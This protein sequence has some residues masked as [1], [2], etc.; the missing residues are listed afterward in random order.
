MKKLLLT[1]L[2]SLT[3]G[4][5]FSTNRVVNSLVGGASG[6]GA[7]SIALGLA[8]IGASLIPGRAMLGATA[9]A[10][11]AAAGAVLTTGR[12]VASGLS[13]TARAALGNKS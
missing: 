8:G 1:G 2:L 4:V 11:R 10:S 6:S 5:I 9:T 13:S 12:S 7:G 3:V